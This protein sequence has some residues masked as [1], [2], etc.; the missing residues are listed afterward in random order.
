MGFLGFFFSGKSV[1]FSNFLRF[2]HKINE[3]S[4]AKRLLIHLEGTKIFATIFGPVHTSIINSEVIDL[5]FSS[6]SNE[7]ISW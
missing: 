1:F 2:L 3:F 7:Q 6:R 5:N 4:K